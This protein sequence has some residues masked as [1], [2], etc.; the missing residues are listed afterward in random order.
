LSG[1]VIETRALD[2][3]IPDW[4]EKGAPLKQ[5]AGED[6]FIYLTETRGFT[7][8]I[9]PPQMKNHGN[10]IVR[11]GHVVKWLGEQA[12]AAGVEVYPGIAAASVLYDDKVP[13]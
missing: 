4:R 5:E 11:L 7:F 1:A 13:P 6:K 10:Y 9:G 3:L 12:E 8:P 2:E